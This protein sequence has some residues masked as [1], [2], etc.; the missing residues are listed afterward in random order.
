MAARRM[1]SN[2]RPTLD[3]SV[4][5][6]LTIRRKYLQKKKTQHYFARYVLSVPN[7]SLIV[8]YTDM[9]LVQDFSQTGFTLEQLDA[10]EYEIPK[11]RE[12]AI[13]TNK[14]Y[15]PYIPVKER[16]MPN[17]ATLISLQKPHDRKSDSFE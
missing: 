4:S 6:F 8:I 3:Y 16:E 5:H 14:R 12:E 10:S 1:E 17:M 7:I 2:R 15:I 9:A 13:E 11:T